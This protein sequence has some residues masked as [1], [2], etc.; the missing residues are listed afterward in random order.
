VYLIQEAGTGTVRPRK[1]EPFLLKGEKVKTGDKL[2]WI[3]ERFLQSQKEE[4]VQGFE[5][6]GTRLE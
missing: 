1:L 4:H 2:L 6:F 5:L 3:R